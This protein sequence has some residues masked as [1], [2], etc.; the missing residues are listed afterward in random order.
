[1]NC[2]TPL[3]TLVLAA[4]AIAVRAGET[5]TPRELTPEEK[6]VAAMANAYMDAFNRGDIKTMAGQFTEDAEWIDTDGDVLSGRGEI[7]KALKAGVAAAPGRR[8]EIDVESV[9]A[10]T[11]DVLLEK[12]TTTT[13]NRDGTA[14]VVSYAAVHVKKGDAWPIAQLP[15]TGAPFDGGASAQLS[16]LEWMIGDWVDNTSGITV[17]V[18]VA[19]TENRTFIT[20]SYTAKRDGK[21]SG[22]GTEVIG[23][24]PTLEKVRSWTFDSDGGFSENVWTEDG[25]RWLIQVKAV[26]PDGSKATAQHTLTRVNDDKFRW[27]SANRVMDDELLPNIDPVE[28]VRAK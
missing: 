13:A 15:E 11:P 12:G 6:A 21:E 16:K 14:N 28:I 17:T 23:W 25:D 19:W 8:L 9:R 24:D 1:M 7:E 10:L 3:L 18:K 4:A 22:A 27:S 2:K 5:E 26:L 20:R